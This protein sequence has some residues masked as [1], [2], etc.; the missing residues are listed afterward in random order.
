MLIK[1]VKLYTIPKG[2]AVAKSVKWWRQRLDIP[3]I[4]SHQLQ[5]KDY[6]RKIHAICT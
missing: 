6:T 5:T 4:Y 3:I 1:G 2:T